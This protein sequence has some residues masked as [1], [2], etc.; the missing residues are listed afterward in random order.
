MTPW[1]EKIFA[2]KFLD[3]HCV[4]NGCQALFLKAVQDQLATIRA[5]AVQKARGGTK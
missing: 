5:A 3:P 2:H 4:E 1:H